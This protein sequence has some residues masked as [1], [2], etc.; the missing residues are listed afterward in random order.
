MA[1]PTIL[2]WRMLKKMAR[3][4][5][6]VKRVVWKFSW[7]DESKYCGVYPD[8]DWGGNYRDMKST[9]GGVW[10]LGEHCI[11]PWSVGQGAYALSS[12]EP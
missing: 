9:S 12:A 7:Q 3:Y 1:N 4:L 5:A 6:G 11:E 2:S 10:V 8:S